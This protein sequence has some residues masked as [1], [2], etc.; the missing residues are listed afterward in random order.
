MYMHKDCNFFKKS[1]KWLKTLT[2]IHIFILKI[3]FYFTLY[4]DKF[5][6]V[7][8]ENH[9]KNNLNVYTYTIFF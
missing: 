1:K 3:H 2:L 8:T 4:K 7:K 9:F 5:K 6:K